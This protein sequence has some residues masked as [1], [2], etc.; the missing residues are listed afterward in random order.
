LQTLNRN[1]LDEK[2]NQKSEYFE[3]GRQVVVDIFPNLHT[4]NSVALIPIP[5]TQYPIPLARQVDLIPTKY[6]S[7]VTG[8]KGPKWRAVRGWPVVGSNAA[9]QEG[10]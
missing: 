7:A 3:Q 10:L 5:N 2:F 6:S 1:I 4:G 8:R 9:P